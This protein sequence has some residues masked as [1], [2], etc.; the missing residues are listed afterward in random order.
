MTWLLTGDFS[1]RKHLSMIAVPKL[2]H[3]YD[4]DAR[5]ERGQQTTCDCRVGGYG[6]GSDWEYS[7]AA[8]GG[9]SYG[10]QP[11]S[12]GGFGA[13]ASSSCRYRSVSS[14]TGLQYMSQGK[15]Y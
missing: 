4:C 7:Y 5:I 12:R 14:H 8:A 13:A 11:R 2:L 9:G 10:Y 3:C 15:L 1:L 6:G